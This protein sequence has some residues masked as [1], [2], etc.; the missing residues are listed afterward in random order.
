M[1]LSLSPSFI[2]SNDP[3]CSPMIELKVTV[4]KQFRTLKRL[5]FGKQDRASQP[6]GYPSELIVTDQIII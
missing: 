6:C 5:F 4:L 2:V 1:H 3:M